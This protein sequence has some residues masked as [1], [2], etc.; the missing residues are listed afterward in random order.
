[1]L[2]GDAVASGNAAVVSTIL[3]VFACPSETRTPFQRP[4]AAM[5]Y[6][7]QAGSDWPGVKTTYDFSGDG[8]LNDGIC[9]SAWEKQARETR[10]MFGENSTTRAADVQ[11]GL[12]K[13]VAVAET[14]Y[15]VLNGECPSWGYRAWVFQGIDLGFDGINTWQS[16]YNPEFPGIPGRLGKWSSAGSLHPGG[17]HAATADG[18]V[19]FL[20]ETTDLVVLEAISTMSGEEVYNSPY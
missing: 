14:V 17:A 18:A 11:D 13:T 4:S 3:P 2:Q 7:V 8:S 15:E 16:R 1:V 6:G 9:C 10:R 20:S 19:H 12:S 5:F